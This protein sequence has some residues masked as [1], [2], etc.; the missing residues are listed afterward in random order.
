MTWSDCSGQGRSS[1]EATGGQQ[2]PRYG[3]TKA[4]ILASMAQTRLVPN[5]RDIQFSADA[6]PVWSR[7][8]RVSSG[9]VTVTCDD[10]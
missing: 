4:A 1:P 3:V 10:L 6:I 5:P 7:H 8:V 2:Q 9:R